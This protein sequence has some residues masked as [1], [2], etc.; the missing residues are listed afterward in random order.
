MLF[1]GVKGRRCRVDEADR[2]GPR[3]LPLAGQLPLISWQSH[4]RALSLNGGKDRFPDP[5]HRIGDEPVSPFPIKASGGIDQPR[6][7]EDERTL[8]DR[9]TDPRFLDGE[10]TLLRGEAEKLVN[11]GLALLD[12]R[13]RT[14]LSWRFGIGTGEA[15]TF[16]EIGTKLGL[17]RERVRQLECLALGRLRRWL[18]RR[19]ALPQTRT[20][21]AVEKC[22]G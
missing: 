19:T 16:G 2:V 22:R 3:R 6:S 7:A 17:S 10:G 12:A 5:P 14:I 13:E 4:E 18:G 20:P 1:L 8:A 15:L 21:T 11:S 9:L